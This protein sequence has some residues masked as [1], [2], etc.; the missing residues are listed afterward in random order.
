MRAIVAGRPFRILELADPN[1]VHDEGAFF[2]WAHP[3]DA[4]SRDPVAGIED[5]KR[6]KACVD[7]VTL[8]PLLLSC[9]GIWLLHRLAPLVYLIVE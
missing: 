8:L 7:E 2:E 6:V 1:D 3:P 9:R 5:G 4:F